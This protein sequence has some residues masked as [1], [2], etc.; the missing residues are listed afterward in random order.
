MDGGVVVGVVQGGVAVLVHMDIQA[1][2]DAVSETVIASEQL[3]PRAVRG[4]AHQA[5]RVL[6]NLLGLEGEIDIPL[7]V[8]AKPVAVAHLHFGRQRQLLG[9]ILVTKLAAAANQRVLGEWR[10]VHPCFGGRL[11]GVMMGMG[12]ARDGCRAQH[13]AGVKKMASVHLLGLVGE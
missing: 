3:S 5:A 13:G 6:V 7:S 4:K 2:G 9:H 12:V 11:I 8:Q 1:V 10:L